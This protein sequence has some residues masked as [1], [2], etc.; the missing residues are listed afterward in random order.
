MHDYSVVFPVL[1]KYIADR[2]IFYSAP[3]IVDPDQMEKCFQ[4]DL[5][6]ID[7]FRAGIIEEAVRFCKRIG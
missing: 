2:Q 7:A 6:L 4:N 5:E 1:L 3:K